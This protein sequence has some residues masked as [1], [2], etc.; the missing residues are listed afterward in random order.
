MR[1][2]PMTPRRAAV[3]LLGQSDTKWNGEKLRR[4]ILDREE[5]LGVTIAPRA[6]SGHMKVTEANLRRYCPELFSQQSEAAAAMGEYRFAIEH[7][8]TEIEERIA[9][10]EYRQDVLSL[11][12]IGDNLPAE[13]ESTL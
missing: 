7:R 3:A 5:S 2:E 1:R 8:F 12:S 13:K 11:A 6:K 4:Y 10:V 9:A